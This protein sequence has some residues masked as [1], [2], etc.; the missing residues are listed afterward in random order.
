[1]KKR[2]WHRY[3]PVTFV[4]FLRTPFCTEHLWWLLL[5]K[6][7]LWDF[8]SFTIFHLSRTSFTEDFLRRAY[9]W[10]FSFT[11][12][13]FLF[14]KKNVKIFPEA[15]CVSWNIIQFV[16]TIKFPSYDHDSV[17]FEER[18]NN[19]NFSCEGYYSF[20]SCLKILKKHSQLCC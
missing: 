13:K 7:F 15:K 8:I 19:F 1:M 20:K 18:I 4:K 11:T 12:L 10:S 2:L 3:F 5:L 17:S 6:A 16:H 14:R 9:R